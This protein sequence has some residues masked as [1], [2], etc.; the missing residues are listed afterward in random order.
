MS[1]PV[2]AA[3]NTNTDAVVEISTDGACL[4]NPGP[5]GWGAVLRYKDKE[6]RISGSDPDTTNNK[7]ELTAAIEGLAALTRPSR[8]I[9]YTDSTYVRNGITKWVAGWQA[10][11]WKTKDKKPVKNADL[12]RRLIEEEQRHQVEWRW[13]KGHAGDH[14]NEIADELATT[15][16]K[17]V[18]R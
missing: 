5:G 16:A 1:Q 17:S 4:G 2:D 10:N 8:V 6:K 7:M 18:A 13:V 11:G 15:A 3:A 9:I 12:W 14:Y